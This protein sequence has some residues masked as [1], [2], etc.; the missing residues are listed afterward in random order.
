MLW[1]EEGAGGSCHPPR[2][3]PEGTWTSQ[4][5]PEV[6]N[7]TERPSRLVNEDI[8][9]SRRAVPVLSVEPDVCSIC[10]DSFTDDDP[11]KFTA[12]GYEWAYG[13]CKRKFCRPASD[14]VSVLRHSCVPMNPLP[15]VAAGTP[16]I[17]S[18]LCSGPKE[19][20]SVR[21]VFDLSSCR[22][23][24]TLSPLTCSGLVPS[25]SSKTL[26]SRLCWSPLVVTVGPHTAYLYVQSSLSGGS[27]FK[28]RN[29]CAQ[30][31]I[32]AYV[33]RIMN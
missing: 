3:F 4:P 33:E 8:E 17:C 26:M 32:P 1:N 21:C 22:S 23:V 6:S 12:C 16:T 29:T 24:K 2:P 28:L 15:F 14:F 18:A 25:L 31:H 5:F 20:V 27:E 13:A 19:A 11:G 10:L 30:R 9:L 7:P